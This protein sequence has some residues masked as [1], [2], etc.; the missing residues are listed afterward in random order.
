MKKNKLTLIIIIVL[1]LTAGYL[2]VNNQRGTLRKELKDFAVKDTA[3]VS[4]IF[5][6]DNFGNKVTL[7][8]VNEDAWMVND[9]YEVR[10]D[11]ID[12]LLKTIYRIEVKSPVSKAAFET[13]VKNM[14]GNATKVEV[15]MGKD[16][17]GKVFYVGGATK[18]NFGTYMMMEN[19][20]VPFIMHIPG[21]YGYLS[22]RFFTD[23][24]DWKT[25]LLY[26]YS[27]GEIDKIE[28]AY[29]EFPE[30]SFSIENISKGNP[31]LKSLKDGKKVENIDKDAVRYFAGS[32]SKVHFEFYA[33]DIAKETR[34]SIIS[35]YPKFTFKITD[36]KGDKNV[37]RAF[38]KPVPDGTK[39]MEGRDI[40][41]DV[42]RMYG[43]TSS[44]DFVIIQHYV[45]DQL[46]P[47]IEFFLKEE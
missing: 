30:H 9:K 42:D 26:K 5:M 7:H 24:K 34:D 3:A 11:A 32:F 16:K 17:P 19:S 38:K 2:Y 44:G 28:L 14:A 46:T 39:D 20:S 22:S 31:M 25:T 33:N 29:D 10:R 47:R 13:V 18:D 15:F 1:A 35:L 12:L 6:A 21:F 8:R 41:F 27:P 40:E 43:L 23:E 4:R 36:T 45:F 37:F